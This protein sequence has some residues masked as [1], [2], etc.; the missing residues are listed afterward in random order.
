MYPSAQLKQIALQKDLLERKLML[1]RTQCLLEWQRVRT[2]F[3]LADRVQSE[4]R[5]LAPLIK[6]VGVPFS[7]FA[8]RRAWQRKATGGRLRQALRWAPMVLKLFAQFSAARRTRA[9][10]GQ[11]DADPVVP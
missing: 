8:A 5:R 4:W 2:P 3:V 10:R 11:R 1:Q 7:L 6:L 9:S